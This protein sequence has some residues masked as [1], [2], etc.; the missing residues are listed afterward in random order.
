MFFIE[1]KNTDVLSNLKTIIFSEKKQ[2]TPYCVYKNK[3]HKKSQVSYH[4][5]LRY[6]FR[7]SLNTISKIKY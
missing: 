4:T 6:I 1:N 2:T 7:D 3:E 5:Y